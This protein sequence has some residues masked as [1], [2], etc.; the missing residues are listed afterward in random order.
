MAK[1]T[2][3]VAKKVK[4]EAKVVER[5]QM[6]LDSIVKAVSETTD[7]SQKDVRTV[8]K[9][10]EDAVVSGLEKGM[11]V[12]MTG[13]LSFKP[14]YRS[15][16]TA[17]NVF[18]GEPMEVPESVGVTVSAGKKLKDAMSNLDPKDFRK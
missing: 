8:L 15:A 9:G 13:F 12:Q 6:N 11:K 3:E 2:K 18:T 14:S 1:K 7:M 5:A 17:N 16:R 4:K 10:L